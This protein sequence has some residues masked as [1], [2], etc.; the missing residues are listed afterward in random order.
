MALLRSRAVGL[1]LVGYFFF[2]CAAC[3]WVCFAF[4]YK[5]KTQREKKISFFFTFFT[6][7]QKN[8]LEQYPKKKAP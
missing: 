1:V 4:S 3:R 6:E 2:V 7:K 5:H 8:N